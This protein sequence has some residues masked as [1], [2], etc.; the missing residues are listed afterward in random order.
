MPVDALVL[1]HAVGFAS[2][3]DACHGEAPSP[4]AA[5]DIRGSGGGRELPNPPTT[6][7]AGASDVVEPLARTGLVN[8]LV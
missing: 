3:A 8:R 7:E 2:G 5:P 4:D 1:N 6:P